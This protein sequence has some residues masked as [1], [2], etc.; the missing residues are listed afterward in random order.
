MSSGDR[1]EFE[2]LDYCTA[3]EESPCQYAIPPKPGDITS[4]WGAP[5]EVRET[6]EEA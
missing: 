1:C 6:W 3:P 4:K 5:D 2:H